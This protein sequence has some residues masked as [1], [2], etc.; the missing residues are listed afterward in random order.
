MA[1]KA[2]SLSGLVGED[3]HLLVAAAFL[4]DIG[5]SPEIRDTGFHALDGARWLRRNGFEPRLAGLVAYHSCAAYEAA[6]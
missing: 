4:H 5:Y 3:Q 2:R 6:E 1:A